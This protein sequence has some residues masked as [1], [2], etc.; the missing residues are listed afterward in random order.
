MT[1]RERENRVFFSLRMLIKGIEVMPAISMAIGGNNLFGRW[2][3]D[4]QVSNGQYYNSALLPP[5]GWLWI[6]R[7]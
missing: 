7:E 2:V 1:K 5:P 3:N 4:W 6:N